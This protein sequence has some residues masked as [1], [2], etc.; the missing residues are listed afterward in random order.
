MPRLQGEACA[1]LAG[2]E[3][4]LTLGHVVHQIVEG[5]GQDAELAGLPRKRDP[6]LVVAP[7]PGLDS[8]RHDLEGARDE[9]A[10]EQSRQGQRE[11]ER[12]RRS[13]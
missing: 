3:R 8:A 9:G 10:A 7:A 6:R 5:L 12:R 2:P 13:A 4:L 1:L 11:D